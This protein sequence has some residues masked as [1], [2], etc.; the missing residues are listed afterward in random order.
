MGVKTAMTPGMII[1]LMEDL[2]HMRTHAMWSHTTPSRQGST[3]P[4]THSLTLLYHS[5]HD[6]LII[7]YP[8]HN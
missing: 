6:C 1:S 8:V 3:R 7:E 2:V 5:T 4:L